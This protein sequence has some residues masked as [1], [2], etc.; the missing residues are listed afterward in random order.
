MLLVIVS[1]M[2]LRSITIA[3]F[4]GLLYGGMPAQ[5][6]EDKVADSRIVANPPGLFVVLK[7][8][9][10]QRHIYH[11]G[12]II[13]IQEDYSANIPGWYLFLQNPYK[14]EG[15][16]PS[17]LAIVPDASLVE[18]VRHSWMSAA[19]IL[20]LAARAKEAAV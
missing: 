18:R 2:P 9:D 8:K 20:G 5:N 6:A 17:N 13:E 14:L 1:D 10:D 7:T 19:A 15:G 16:S 3:A 11:L 12:E 4:L